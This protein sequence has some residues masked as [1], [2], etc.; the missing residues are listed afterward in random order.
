MVTQQKSRFHGAPLPLQDVWRLV[1]AVG[2]SASA[3]RSRPGKQAWLVQKLLAGG[4][5]AE[6][7]AR[8]QGAPGRL[9]CAHGERRECGR[10]EAHAAGLPAARCHTRARYSRNVCCT[11]A[12]LQNSCA[13][14][15]APAHPRD[16]RTAVDPRAFRNARGEC[17]R[18]ARRG[19]GG[20]SVRGAAHGLG[21]GLGAPIPVI[22]ARTGPT[23]GRFRSI[24]KGTSPTASIHTYITTY[25]LC[26][27]KRKAEFRGIPFRNGI[28]AWP[29]G[30]PRNCYSLKSNQRTAARPADCLWPYDEL[31]EGGL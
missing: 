13:P 8:V 16:A 5:V 1:R 18:P 7:G 2:I 19:H 4:T 22:G 14:H 23:S 28:P 31:P 20:V 17:R 11:A 25:L 29:T 24:P 27:R 12:S 9:L 10:Q 15:S 30:I 3:A 21:G 26:G 6:L